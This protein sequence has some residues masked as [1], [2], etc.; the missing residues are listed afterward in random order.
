MIKED[1]SLLG[2]GTDIAKRVI[3]V[4]KN[5]TAH[6]FIRTEAVSHL[7]EGKKQC[8]ASTWTQWDGKDMSEFLLP[9]EDS[10]NHEHEDHKAVAKVEE[11]VQKHWG[12]PKVAEDLGIPLED[13][14]LELAK[15]WCDMKNK[16][17]IG[18]YDSHHVTHKVLLALETFETLKLVGTVRRASA[19]GGQFSIQFG[20]GKE[21][22][23]ATGQ[24]HS[25]LEDAMQDQESV[26]AA[27][28]WFPFDSSPEAKRKAAE[29]ALAVQQRKRDGLQPLP[30]VFDCCRRR[31]TRKRPS[32]PL[33]EDYV[34]EMSQK[35]P[36]EKVKKEVPVEVNEDVSQKLIH[37][38]P[39]DEESARDAQ[40]VAESSRPGSKKRAAR[41]S[42]NQPR[43]E[44]EKQKQIRIS[45]LIDD[46]LL[47]LETISE[48]KLKRARAE[49]MQS[50]KH[51][52][53][54]DPSLK[55]DEEA[56]IQHVRRKI[57]AAIDKGTDTSKVRR[58]KEVE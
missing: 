18:C 21:R 42:L 36:E 4:M 37:K 47:N 55:D 16:L 50:F 54:Q 13:G 11:F 12:L 45:N 33:E 57:Q 7:T 46:G 19:A 15:V 44:T 6:G 24:Q 26:S 23:R 10:K 41:A 30:L 56:L 40:S 14:E 25:T 29:K 43:A 39:P 28:D 35:A 22:Q 2:T 52:I 38:V 27:I 53:E 51:T 48:S 34:K 3:E 9:H 20:K 32:E 31:V 17:R 5:P 8:I 1:P 49:G 58:K